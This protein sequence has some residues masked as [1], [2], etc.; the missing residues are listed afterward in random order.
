MLSQSQS[1]ASPLNNK[2]HLV[3]SISQ[4]IWMVSSLFF[5]TDEQFG[6]THDG[7]LIIRGSVFLIVILRKIEGIL[8]CPSNDLTYLKLLRMKTNDPKILCLIRRKL[9]IMQSTRCPM[10]KS[11]SEFNPSQ[12]H[13]N[14]PE[15][16]TSCRLVIHHCVR[17]LVVPTREIWNQS[18]K[19][20]ELRKFE[21]DTTVILSDQLI[22]TRK[23]FGNVIQT[24]IFCI[25][26]SR[27]RK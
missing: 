4:S 1:N 23:A 15:T 6:V 25:M 18:C 26:N 22:P 10:Y 24:R 12:L 27:I 19:L 21:I 11:Y 14:A 20:F 3:I 13:H 7:T 5:M 9:L 16:V 2:G 8:M 17:L